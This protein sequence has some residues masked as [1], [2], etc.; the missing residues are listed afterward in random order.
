MKENGESMNFIFLFLKSIVIGFFMLVPGISGG[1]IAILLNIYD[2]LL[3][4][5]NNIFKTFKSSV[6]F[7]AVASV[8]GIIG[9]FL[10]S[11]VLEFFI[12]NFYFEIIFLFL[13][14]MISYAFKMLKSVEKK[15]FLRNILLI[16]IG[17]AVGILITKIPIGFLNIKNKYLNLLFVGIFLAVA[18][19]LPG[20]SVSYVLLIFSMYSELLIAIQQFDILYLLEIGV[21]LIVGILLVAKILNYFLINKKS[22][23]E[24]IIVGFIF[25]SIW[26]IL[27]DI[28]NEKELVYAVIFILLGIILK[29]IFNI[30]K[31]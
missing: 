4:S 3:L 14:L 31:R 21:A 2:D 30:C 19:I 1:S 28:T 15:T 13:G 10:S 11:Y 7:L 27:P 26:I 25:S 22:F 6:T 29:S 24:N 12:Q 23:V 8:G 16:F 9:L 18:L 5:L 17:V 20:I